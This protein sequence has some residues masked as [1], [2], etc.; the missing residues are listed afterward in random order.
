MI[1]K[2]TNLHTLFEIA[3]STLNEVDSGEIFIV[4]DL[5]R[6]FEWARIPKGERTKLG[7][8]VFAYANGDIGS[9]IIEPVGKTPQ[10]QQKYKKL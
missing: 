10:N 3:M 1:D 9:A 6:G 2:N 5:F 8:M 7:S 4:R